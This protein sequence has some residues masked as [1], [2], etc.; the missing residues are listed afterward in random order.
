MEKL[1]EDYFRQIAR[2]GADG[3]QIDK[4]VTSTLLDFNPLNTLKPD[5]ALNQGLVNAIGR[6]YRKCKAINPD[7]CL[8]G[9]ALQDRLIPYIDVYYRAVGGFDMA[10]LRYTFPEWTSCRHVGAPRDFNGVNAAVLVGAVLCV[11][12]DLYQSSLA[13]PLYE[14]IANYIR[15]TERIRGELRD[16]IFLGDYLDTLGAGVS[17]VS[18]GTNAAASSRE[19]AAPSA[20]SQA[21]QTNLLEYRVHANRKTGHRAI[22]VVNSSARNRVYTWKWLGR[23]ADKAMLHEPF[24]PARAV[25]TGDAIRIK[26]ERFHVLVEEQ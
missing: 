23:P 7:F 15:E 24:E 19:V 9:E 17:E 20:S 16:T 25:K 11:E 12:P 22:V 4:L 14:D 3:L 1:L 6:L 2:D 8:A 21:Q 18:E 26:A 5:V 10:P 13:N